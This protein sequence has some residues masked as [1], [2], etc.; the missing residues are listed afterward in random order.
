MIKLFNIIILYC[1]LSI[2][3]YA[4]DLNT[5]EGDEYWEKVDSL[6]WINGPTTI[7]HISQGTIFIDENHSALIGEDAVQIMY[8]INGLQFDLDIFVS[9]T[10]TG[11]YIDYKYYNEGYV[12]L[13]DWKDVNPDNFLKE[14]KSGMKENNKERES[15]GFNTVKNIKWLREPTLNKQ[16]NTVSY[17]TSLLFSDNKYSVNA[18]LLILGRYGHVEATYVEGQEGFLKNG[19]QALDSII[20]NYNFVP[21]KEYSKFTTGDK[22]AAAGIGGLLAAS[23]GVKAFKAGGIAALLLILKKA[24]FIIFIPFIFAWG[25]IKRLF[26]RN[27]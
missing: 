12:K 8:W 15:R 3:S 4:I 1:F 18:S 7:N 11:S 24:W 19:N 25:W 6:N 2:P 5:Y 21:E 17:A 27:N 23:L 13:E 14:L 9:N 16:K 10:I 22:V 26:S 20:A